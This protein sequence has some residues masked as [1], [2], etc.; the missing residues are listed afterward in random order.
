MQDAIPKGDHIFINL[1][2]NKLQ[3]QT[4]SIKV[5]QRFGLREH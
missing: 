5:F 4:P 3:G 2:S 1:P